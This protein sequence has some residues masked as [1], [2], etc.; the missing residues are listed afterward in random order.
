MSS[1]IALTLLITYF[2]ILFLISW[3]TS[4]N[5]KTNTFFTGDRKSPWWV[6]AFGM[7]GTTFSGITFVSVPGMVASKQFTYIQMILGY[8]LGYFV[9]AKVL[10]PLYY[11]YQFISIYSY[12]ENRLGYW[13]YKTGALFF[14]LSRT[15]GAAVRLFLAATVLQTFLFEDLGIPF[16]ATVFVTLFFIWIYTLHGGIKTVVWTDL[17]QTSFLLLAL[18]ITVFFLINLLD[19]NLSEAVQKVWYSEYSKI[20]VW[21]I[22]DKSYFLKDFL[23]GVF[24]AITMTGLDQDMM[25]KNLTCKTLFSSQK[26]MYTF[27]IALTLA[28]IVFLFMGAL[29]Y[30]F[31]KTNDIDIPSHGDAVFPFLSKSHLGL[32]TAIA[33]FIGIIAAAYSSADSALTGLTTSFCIDFLNFNKSK[34][35]IAKKNRLLVH[36]GFSG[37][38]FF[39]I[40]MF[41]YTENTAMVT[42][43]FKAAS[44]TYGPLLGL[45]SFGL[46]NKH[47]V[48]DHYVPLVCIAAPLICYILNSFSQDWLMGYQFGYELLIVNGSLT[49]LGLY[50][51]RKKA[52]LT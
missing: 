27:S 33:F 30:L 8:S 29:L 35:I 38:L 14:L 47:Q 42:V 44:Y 25:Q 43:L 3:K 19:M 37:V 5:T 23:G 32:I 9:I 50:I 2:G 28:N 11:K 31:A 36:L 4:R 6:V 40:M 13:S 17:L 41:Y 49:F 26:N 21:D 10:L 1:H 48:K 15:I 45:F 39:V 24:L 7:L 34:Q 46:L 22:Q 52:L 51:F 20:F 16:P 12:L 18:L